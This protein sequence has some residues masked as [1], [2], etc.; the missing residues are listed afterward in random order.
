MIKERLVRT[1]LLIALILTVTCLSFGQ[2]TTSRVTGVVTDSSGAAVPGAAVTLKNSATGTSLTTETADNGQYTFDL[3]QAGV[4]NLTIEKTGFKKFVSTGNTAYI[5]QPTTINVA[6]EIGDV[7]A[8]VTVVGAA[9]P[10]QT[11]TSGN[12]GST[13]EQRTLESLPIVGTRGRNP[14]DLLNFQPGVVAG[15]NAGGLVNVHGSRDR[16][17]NYT[18]DG[19]DINESTFGGSNTTPLKP[20][21]ESIQEFQIVTSNPTAELGRSSGAQVT[22]VTRSGTNQFHGNLF[23]FYQTPRFNAK[24]YSETINKQAKGQFVQ[25]I[26]GGSIGGPVPNFGL[27]EGNDFKLLRNK[28]F[29]FVNMQYLRAVDALSVT[30]TVYTESA[31]AGLYRWVA[32]RQNGAAGTSTASVN[33]AGA[34]IFPTCTGTPP[35]NVPCIASYNGAT[36]APVAFDP[37]LRSYINAMPLPNN[38]A[39]GDGLNTAGFTWSAPGREKYLDFVT[40]IDYTLNQKNAFYV[41]YGYGDQTSPSDAINLG[42]PIYPGTP[43]IV[44]TYRTPRNLAANWRFSPTSRLTNEFIYGLSKYGFKFD[45]PEPDPVYAFSFINVS[46]SNLNDSYNAR[47]VKTHQIVDNITFDMSPHT[48]KAG[49]NF[50]LTRHLDDR[51]SVAGSTIEGKVTFSTTAAPYTGYNLPLVFNTTTNPTGINSN[52]LTRLQATLADLIGRVGT[53]SRAFVSDP[54]NPSAFAPGGARWLNSAHYDEYDSYIQDNWKMRSNLTLDLG[55]RWEIKMSPRVDGRPILVPDQPV[56][57]GAAPSNTLK[58]TEGKLFGNEYGLFLPSIGFAWDP[59]NSGKT[60]IR[61]NYRLATDRYPTFLF[62]SSIFQGTPGN[63]VSSSNSAF[64]QAGGLFSNYAAP[65]AALVPTITPAAARQP[66]ALSSNTLSVVDPELSYPK[67]HSFMVSF[68]REITK[69]NVFEFNYIRKNARNLS[70]GYNINQVNLSAT[71]PRCPGQTFLDAFKLAQDPAVSS[72]CLIPFLMGTNNVPGTLASFRTT[73]STDLASN[74]VA[75]V[76]QTLARRTGTTALTANA[77]SPFFFMPFPQFAGGLNVFDSNDY[78]N[79]NGFEF[80]FKR[81]ITSGLGFQM[82]YTWSVSKDNRS[83]DP[84][85][86]T[87][88]TGNVQSA[89]STPFDVNNRDL[90]YTW[91]DFD[92]RHVFQS[93]WVYELPFGQGRS[94]KTG[95]KVLDYVIGGWQVAG[96]LIWQSGRPFTVY[97]GFNT[98]TNIVQSTADCNGCPRNLGQL[99]LETG[100]NFWFDGAARARFS[101]PAAGKNGNTGRNYFITPGYFQPDASL[102][103]KFR[104]NERFSFDLRVDAKNLL[105]H[106]NFDLPTATINN[107]IFGRIND[108]VTNTARKIQ[109]SGKLNF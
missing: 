38:F 16:A 41:R 31:R 24:S 2:G 109:W 47:F 81:R 5:N 74:N 12:V 71:D 82:A 100:R 37:V 85:Q 32:G 88:S 46:N 76:A 6:L 63:N 77:F 75:T 87:V 105:N 50:R 9:E 28:L 42:R 103:R 65:F 51:Y 56:K 1:S 17:F 79:Y 68:Q 84:T 58:W 40:K 99:V 73:F 66:P 101:L 70:G 48:I 29:F 26:Y 35:T 60:S 22:L 94:F 18:L 33:A 3:V 93:T 108:S 25:H 98:F 97:A 96:T 52:D 19:I 53:I 80:I 7:S 55:M 91:S 69:N 83:F 45:T 89:S 10:V 20:N 95:N 102:V 106:P 39:T 107:S 44:N 92:R 43:N 13:V 27:G 78:S 15:G 86:T 61:A 8:T 64:G 57:V 90:N 30:R 72:V 54:S 49:V 21:P 4:Y 36:S 23:E 34:P 14:L 104:L 62:G 11:S 67:V 59:F